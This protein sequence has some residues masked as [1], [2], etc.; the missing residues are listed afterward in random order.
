[1]THSGDAAALTRVGILGL[2]RAGSHLAADLVEAGVEVAAFDPG[3]VPTPEGVDRVAVAADVAD[4]ADLV[5]AATAPLQAPAALAQVLDALPAGSLYADMSTGSPKLKRGLALTLGRAGIDF[6]GVAILSVVTGIGLSAP[7]LVSGSGAERYVE[8]L[9]PLGAPVEAV[10]DEPGLAASRKLLRGIMI[11][12][13]GAL[14]V[15]VLQA[16]HGANDIEWLWQNLSTELAHKEE[17]WLETIL[18]KFVNY[19]IHR[20]GEMESTPLHLE[21]LGV[22]PLMTRATVEMVRRVQQSGVPPVPS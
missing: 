14:A 8:L 19:S 5:L 2:G 7:S 3:S 11:R 15:E 6:A 1:M 17:D 16:G 4:G 22:D 9:T 18:D 10:G 20:R 21:D 12:G 13:I